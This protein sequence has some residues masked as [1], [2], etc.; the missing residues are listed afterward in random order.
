MPIKVRCQGCRAVFNVP[1][2]ARGRA[3]RRPKCQ[4]KFRVPAREPNE[5][6]PARPSEPEDPLASLDLSEL[7]DRS[8]RVCPR[9]GTEVSE[10]DIECPNCFVDLSTGVMREAT[11][12]RLSRK[13]P[14]PALYYRGVW[15]DAWT[16]TMEQ[17]PLVFRTIFY[18]TFWTL[19]SLG[20]VFMVSWCRNMPP[21]VF[22]AFVAAVTGLVPL[23][24]LWHLNTEIVAATV[25]RK[26]QLPRIPFDFFLCVAL[27]IKAIAWELA[28]C[29]Q[30][31]V[32]LIGLG[33][34]VTGNHLLGGILLGVGVAA[35]LPLLPIAFAH[36]AMPVSWPAWAINKLGEAFAKT[37]VPP[38][39]WC[40]VLFV[41][42]LPIL[43][44]LGGAAAWKGRDVARM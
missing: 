17:K 39:Y 9:C 35:T 12:R 13:G 8:V 14:D 20:C 27:G 15:K 16:F 31:V 34:L 28:M 11:R 44:L 21:R 43:G 32:S 29:V 25:N 33:L 40:L 2:A 42:S 24:W 4:A 26:E 38:L 18:L 3:I 37:L 19:V 36:M 23:G 7:E 30:T 22:W 41:T 5:G 6:R 10:E 1:D